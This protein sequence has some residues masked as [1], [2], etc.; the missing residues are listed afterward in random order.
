MEENSNFDQFLFDSYIFF[1]SNAYCK[2][3]RAQD[4][5]EEVQERDLEREKKKT[6]PSI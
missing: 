4:L 2:F 6:S 3:T 5:G 1:Q